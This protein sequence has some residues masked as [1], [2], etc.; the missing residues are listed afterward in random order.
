VQA[1]NATIVLTAAQLAQSTLTAGTGVSDDLF[2]NV[3]V[4]VAFGEPQEFH[5]LV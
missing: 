1:A 2:V 4:G 5:I 3:F